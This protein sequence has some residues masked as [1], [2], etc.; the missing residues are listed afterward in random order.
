MMRDAI[1]AVVGIECKQETQFG[2]VHVNSAA[3]NGAA[4][5]GL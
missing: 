1:N 4:W 5:L 2:L 3:C